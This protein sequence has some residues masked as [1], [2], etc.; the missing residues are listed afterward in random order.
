MLF[1]SWIPAKI[2]DKGSIFVSVIRDS[3]G[4]II[5]ERQFD[6]FT[7]IATSHPSGLSICGIEMAY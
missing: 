7:L 5:M 4:L 1:A 2:I 6:F 3:F